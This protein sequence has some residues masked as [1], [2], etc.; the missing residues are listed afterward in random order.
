[1]NKD[2]KAK[3]LS[4]IGYSIL[5][6]KYDKEQQSTMSRIDVNVTIIKHVNPQ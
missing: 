1:M 2:Y 5:N 4:A 6:K 3:E